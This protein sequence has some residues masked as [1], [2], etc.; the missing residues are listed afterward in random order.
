MSK[1]YSSPLRV[2]LLLGALALLGI[3]SGMKLPVSLF[4]NSSK[5]VV[6]VRIPFG[7]MTA[8][9]FLNTYGKRLEDQIRAITTDKIEV[10]TIEANY[11]SH[12]ATYNIKFRWG[13]VPTSALKE[14]QN[15]TNA[16]SARLPEESRDG[17]WI[18]LDNENSGFFAL[19]F[20]SETR[21]LDALYDYLEPLIGPRVSRVKDAQ[22]PVLWNPS[23]K[24]VRVELIPETMASLQLF[25]RDIDEAIRSALG[26]QTGGSV[27]VGTNVLQIEMP[28][29]MRTVEELRQVSIPTPSGKAVHLGDIAHVSLGP[30][31]TDSHSFKTNG[32]A[33]L[34]LYSSPKPGGNV[35]RMSEDIL[36]IVKELEPT[37]PKD[38]QYRI[39]VDPSEFI[40]SAVNNVFHEVGIAAMLAVLV[41]F[42]FIGS[43]RNVITAA[44]EIPMS[45]VLAF[46]LMRIS[47]MNLNLISL[48]GLA[49][50]AG[51]NVDASVVVMENIFRHFEMHP[52]PHDFS[53]RLRI[54]TEAV[55]EVQF[56]VIASTIASL[57]V[58]LPLTF[59]SDLSYAILG[60]LALAVVFSHGFSAFVALLLVPTVRLHLMAGG[61]DAGH[62]HSPIEKQ[63]KW[64]ENTYG[65][66]L[67][68]FI[69]R[70]RLKWITY[71]G[72]GALLVALAFLVIPRLPKEIVGTPD[73]DWMVLSI[74]TQGNT[75]LKQMEVQAEEIE[76]SL[77]A[78]FGDRIQYT[79]TQVRSPNSGTIMARL[80]E[81][82]RMR[83][84]WKAMEKRFTNT[85][86]LFFWVGPWNPSELPIPDP[87][88]MR[89]AIRG[90]ELRDRAR[91]ARDLSDLMQ[92]KKV[93][94][95]ISTQPVA[96][97]GDTITLSPHIEQ[98]AALRERGA[99]F[100]TGDL[101]DLVRV[102]TTGR[103]TGYFPMK[104]TLTQIILR[105]PQGLVT[106]IEDIA[107][108]PVGIGGKIIPLKALTE[109]ETRESAPMIYREDQREIF[110]VKGRQN[111]GEGNKNNEAALAKAHALV[112]D[113]EA[114]R[115]KPAPD[116]M[117]PTVTFED[118]AKDLNDAIHQLTTAVALSILLIFLTLL[119]QFGTLIEPLL[120]LVSIPLGFIGVLVSL[121][122]FRSTLSLNSI[123][124]V[125]LLNGISVANSIILVDF[126]KRLVDGGKAP[127]EA[128]V[129]AA[130][131]RLRPILITSLTTVLGMLPIALGRGEG[132]HILQPLGIAVSGGLWVSMGLTLFLVPALQVSYLEWR[133]SRHLG[134]RRPFFRFLETFNLR[135][136]LNGLK[137][138]EAATPLLVLT[139]AAFAGSAIAAPSPQALTFDQAL[140]RIVDRDTNVEIQRANL[141]SLRG[142]NLPDRLAL[143]PSLSLN[144]KSLT[145]ESLGLKSDRRG[146]EAVGTLNVFRFGA[147]LAGMRAASREEEA[148][149][150]SI[151]D[152]L[153]KAEAGGVQALVGL[154]QARLE[155][156]VQR[157]IVAFWD[158]F[159]KTGRERYRRGL[160]AQ[161]EVDKITVDY[162]N[163]QAQLGDAESDVVKAEASL[164]AL[165]GEDT[166]EIAWPWRQALLDHGNKIPGP[167]E[168]DLSK[169]P[170]WISAERRVQSAEARASQGWGRMLPSLDLTFGYGYWENA[171]TI[172]PGSYYNGREWSGMVALTIPLF[173]KLSNY[174]NYESLV[175]RRKIAELEL[176]QIRRQAKNDWESARGSLDISLRTARSRDATLAVSRHLYEDNLKRLRQGMASANDLSV[177]QDRLYRSELYAIRGWGNVHLSLTRLCHAMGRRVEDCLHDL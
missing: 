16:F 117:L 75:L 34:I 79:F 85:P 173:D 65:G 12:E 140:K 5:P 63:L 61:R 86:T 156:G 43:F 13:V 134:E 101:A 45:M 69:R 125:I 59:T 150:L 27:T 130:R 93:F 138:G 112:A 83:E 78:E 155:L 23:S 106:G 66:A 149:E 153:I 120:V 168:A 19:S 126:I 139:L 30:K 48:G 76:R 55:R 163:A 110:L 58:F 28:R 92:E 146:F 122:V 72:L 136:L 4:P 49:L 123:L 162:D 165:L 154:I 90:G 51:M 14:V 37:L 7:S 82:S 131:K 8:E 145:S 108:L 159:L 38:I 152:A 74:N 142:R 95:R 1:L 17:M 35:K 171:N 116:K 39:L 67:G 100:S 175:Y 91:V 22:D 166:I 113:W 103:F 36:Q 44:I 42:L 107:A 62:A 9:E 169:R 73:T 143:L 121:F 160:L 20:F 144:A 46:I 11:G 124:G 32:A 71:G 170:D 64:L 2:Y 161:Q 141:G 96:D 15:T 167:R 148:Q 164:R 40:R 98:W 176:E 88:D 119:F 177:D 81:K 158:D 24:E 109:V 56:A 80:R 102:A 115:P 77:L 111:Q 94:P 87:P 132:G 118:A 57:V 99:R 3:F 31:T 29:Q 60:D 18:Y 114:K 127:R 21:D 129:E 6:F 26:G 151:T 70:P 84:T 10:E 50:S 54:V 128:A 147:D 174:G 53:S 33:S 89:I 47:G 41:L 25:P 97:T 133:A 135:N 52:G 68:T 157:Q 105:Y 172:F 137:P 104:D